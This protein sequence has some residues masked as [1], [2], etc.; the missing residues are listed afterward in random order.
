MDFGPFVVLANCQHH[1]RKNLPVARGP[2]SYKKVG[3][4]VCRRRRR[5]RRPR[6]RLTIS[7]LMVV[8]VFL[9]GGAAGGDRGGRGLQGEVA[10]GRC[11]GC[12]KFS[13]KKTLC[14]QQMVLRKIKYFLKKKNKME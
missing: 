3:Q 6:H 12:N 5:L 2:G 4:C 8:G 13:L 10:K 9:V 14:F 11:E 1:A 7:V